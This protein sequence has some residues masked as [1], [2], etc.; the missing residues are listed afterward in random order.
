VANIWH[1]EESGDLSVSAVPDD[2]R[3]VVVDRSRSQLAPRFTPRKRISGK[4]QIQAPA[5]LLLVRTGHGVDERWFVLP[6]AGTRLR[7]N[8][9]RVGA[10]LSQLLDR[11]VFCFG[12]A[13]ADVWT[14][15]TERLPSVEIFTGGDGLHCPRCKLELQHGGK[16]VACPECRGLHHQDEAAGKPCWTYAPTCAQCNRE[17]RLTDAAYS[18]TPHDL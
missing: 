7:R 6:Y 10:G 1:V 13:D 3:Y 2:S 15:T 11:D 18:W 17:T 8:G 9:A 16:V 5:R 12:A 14:F 4:T